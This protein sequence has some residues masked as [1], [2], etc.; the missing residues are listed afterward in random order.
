[1]PKGKGNKGKAIK[2][3]SSDKDDKGAKT[4]LKP[5]KLVMITVSHHHKRHIKKTQ[6]ETQEEKM[7]WQRLEDAG[8]IPKDPTKTYNL[9]LVY[10]NLT[11][12]R[13]LKILSI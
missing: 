12:N 5:K 11:L 6:M 13:F 8:L 9:F 1:M 10:S 2:K 3:K 7:R 4:P